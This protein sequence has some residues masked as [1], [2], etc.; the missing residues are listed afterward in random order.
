MA[1]VIDPK[2]LSE[3]EYQEYLRLQAEHDAF[4]AEYTNGWTEPRMTLQE[5]IAEW[6]ETHE[7]LAK[8][9]CAV[10]ICI[11]IMLSACFDVFGIL[12]ATVFVGALGIGI[13]WAFGTIVYEII[14][15]ALNR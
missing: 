11:A 14:D 15:A 3:E 13:L 7:S 8:F 12:C 2:G 6:W 9:I 5:Q 1:L 10:V 4:W